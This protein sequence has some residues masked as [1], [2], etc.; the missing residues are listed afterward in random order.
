MLEPE[1]LYTEY[2][3]GMCLDGTDDPAGDS[4]RKGTFRMFMFLGHFGLGF[5]GKRV[6]PALSLGALFL[7]VQGSGGL[8]ACP[9]F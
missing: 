6:A 8:G 9:D 2:I 7:A 1:T 5:A 3:D 4:L